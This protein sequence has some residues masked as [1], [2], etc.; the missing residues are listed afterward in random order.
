MDNFTF[1]KK[2][3]T[4][5]VKEE[6]KAE[7]EKRRYNAQLKREIAIQKAGEEEYALWIL[8]DTKNE[9]IHNK[10]SAQIEAFTRKQFTPP[11]AISLLSKPNYLMSQCRLWFRECYKKGIKTSYG[12]LWARYNN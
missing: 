12:E 9:E 1:N 3:N 8:E 6:S 10:V 2:T 4:F 11:T 5:N 7:I